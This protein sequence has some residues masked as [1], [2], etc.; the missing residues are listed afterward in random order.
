MLEINEIKNRMEDLEKNQAQ[1]SRNIEGLLSRLDQIEVELHKG[2]KEL[3]ETVKKEVNEA[4]SWEMEGVKRDISVGF[5]IGLRKLMQYL[6]EKI[7]TLFGNVSKEDQPSSSSNHHKIIPPKRK[8][9][10][11]EFVG[12]HSPRPK[13]PL[14]P[15]KPPISGYQM[16]PKLELSKFNGETKLSVAWIN[17]AEEFFSIHKSHPTKK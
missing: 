9:P 15:P 1:D 8:I 16:K 12:D 17:K 10:Q 14:Y 7:T 5:K 11:E 3:S 6:E 4:V 2:K 13:Q